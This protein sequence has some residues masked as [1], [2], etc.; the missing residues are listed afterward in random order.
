MIIDKNGKLFGK[1]SVIDIL[2]VFVIVLAL[3]GGYLRFSGK[4][5]PNMGK[6]TAIEYCVLV[7]GVRSFSVDALKKGGFVF[8]KKTGERI[9]EIIKVSESPATS[10]SIKADGSYV[11]AALPDKFDVRVTVETMGRS[12][13]LGIFDSRNTELNV[14]GNTGIVSKWVSSVGQIESIKVKD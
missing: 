6:N 5:A 11:N 2:A 4:T 13:D 10:G 8:D 3:L 14:G 12:G 1:I 9:G 7:K